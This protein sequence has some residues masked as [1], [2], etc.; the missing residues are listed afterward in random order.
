MD[1]NFSL[2][3]TLAGERRETVSALREDLEVKAAIATIVLR[4]QRS[5]KR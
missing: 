3:P 4:F 2:G 1:P 5:S